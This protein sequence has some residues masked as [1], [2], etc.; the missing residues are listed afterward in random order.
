MLLCAFWLSPLPAMLPRTSWSCPHSVLMMF[1]C[2]GW[3]KGAHGCQEGLGW[4]T[5][6]H[7]SV[8]AMLL[9]TRVGKC[10]GVELGSAIRAAHV[11][12]IISKAWPIRQQQRVSLDSTK[13]LPCSSFCQTSGI[14]LLGFRSLPFFLR[15]RSKKNHR[16]DKAGFQM[17][18]M[19]WI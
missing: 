15:D 8:L 7:T 5:E 11:K 18:H 9:S 19:F 3:D 16:G 12:G 10:Q 13:G 4:G 6:I 17:K 2:P 1:S 14:L